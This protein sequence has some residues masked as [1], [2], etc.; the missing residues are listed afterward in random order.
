M[1][2]VACSDETTAENATSL[3]VTV[4]AGENVT[5]TITN[6]RRGSIAVTKQIEPATDLGRFDLKVDSTIVRNAAADNQGGTATGLAPGSYTASELADE[7]SPT[8]LADYVSSVACSGETTAQNATSLQVTVS[9]GENVTCTIT[10]VRKAQLTVNKVCQPAN[11][12]GNFVLAVNPGS[13]TNAVVCGGSLGP[14]QLTPGSY[15]VSET[16]GLNTNLS[17]YVVTINGNC[18]ASGAITLAPG[19]VATCTVTN[20]RKPKL[21]VTKLCPNGKQSTE[22]RFES[23]STE[24]APAG[25]SE[26]L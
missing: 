5:C 3:Q 11:D 20:A 14:V 21:T 7:G 15:T 26:Y 9:A 10:N 16:A 25:S 12:P 13:H 17:D 6:V 24:R 19:Q 2:S 4:S 22:D 23:S 1:S 18:A 8:T